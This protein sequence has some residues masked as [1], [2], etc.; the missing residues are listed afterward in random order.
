MSPEL[1]V[2]VVNIIINSNVESRMGYRDD[3]FYVP[4]FYADDGLLLA[5]SCWLNIN[6]G[7]AMYY[8]LTMMELDWKRFEE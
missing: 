1:F 7:R 2:M 4:V 5:R 3:D 6:K 8:Y